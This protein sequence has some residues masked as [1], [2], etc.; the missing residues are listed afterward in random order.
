MHRMRRLAR[1]MSPIMALL[2]FV[3]QAFADPGKISIKDW[4]K[5][6]NTK[7]AAATEASPEPEAESSG[8]QSE[9][10]PAEALMPAVEAP[11]TELSPEPDPTPQ[12][13]LT[14]PA[15]KAIAE[16]VKAEE[17]SPEPEMTAPARVKSV[18]E[19]VQAAAEPVATPEPTPEPSAPATP[20]PANGNGVVIPPAASFSAGQ[21]KTGAGTIDLN[22]I[23]LDKLYEELQ[24][25]APPREEKPMSLS[26]AVQLALTNNQDIKVTAYEPLKVD[27]DILAA[28]GEFDP[29]LSGKYQKSNVESK[30][31]S[32]ISSFTGGLGGGGSSGL[33]G[34]GNS[35]IL[36]S[37]LRSINNFNLGGNDDDNNN[38]NLGLG[39]L[40][41][42]G[43]L[44]IASSAGNSI[45]NFVSGGNEQELI[46][47]QD[48]STYE[49]TLQG[50]IPWG[51]QYQVKLSVVD[52]ASTYSGNV[53]EFSGGLTLSLTQPLLRGR[54]PKANLA[55]IKIA[56]NSRE[57]AENQLMTQVMTTVSDVVKAYW[58]LVGAEQQLAVRV[59]SLAN[60]QNL[61]DV[62]QRRFEIG[63]GA[64]L[65]VVQ[66]KASVAQRTSDVIAARNQV[67]SAEDRLKLLLDLKENEE[68]SHKRLVATDIPEATELDLD[69]QASVTRAFENR[70]EMRSA[71]LEIDSAEHDRFRAANNMQAKLD[72]SGSL[73]QGARGEDAGVVFEGIG[74]RDDNSYSFQID[75]EIPITN[76]QARGQYQ[77]ALQTKHQA[78]D[79]LYKT[80][81]E[82]AINVRNAIRQAASNRIIVE[83]SG[84]ARSLQETNVSAEEKRLK[85]GITT[86]FEVLRTQEDLANAHAQEV[87]AKIDYEKSLI[88]LKLAE[89]T[90]LTALNVEYAAPAPE[91]PIGFVRSIVPPVP[92][93]E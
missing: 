76:R 80:K 21:V 65:E 66:A 19:W 67:G 33:L 44:T 52:E 91:K 31:S 57:I 7:T 49:A 78:K 38:N 61:M 37:V 9:A 15:K 59:Q 85:L 23:N 73:F 13:V 50:K 22:A 1:T 62:N 48:S 63:I 40:L 6:G 45:R 60:A 2:I 82:V 43:A 8:A 4:A 18:N 58:D 36:G 70:P 26:E 56:K 83:S 11:E 17:S 51:T 5:Q 16:P 46:I 54:G 42:T 20:P 84:Q 86:S 92:K 79:K 3:G 10:I 55:R 14:K 64:A 90:I 32:Q 29:V 77:K 28:K 93:D 12:A 71:E 39:R 27:G 68:F 74:N 72:V 81:S 88:D 87:Q 47:E 89:G 41:L 30:A 35:N 69:E 25:A 24:K 53:S 34:G 75:G